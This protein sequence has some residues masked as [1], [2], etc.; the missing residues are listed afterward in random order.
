VR[1]LRNK[2]SEKIGD[3]KI[4]KIIRHAL[5]RTEL[6]R[7]PDVLPSGYRDK[8]I[9]ETRNFSSHGSRRSFCGVFC[10]R[11]LCDDHGHVE[12][13]AMVMLRMLQ[14]RD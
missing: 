9:R 10:L 14:V 1:E 5:A 6:I 2:I 12:D 13:V 3:E 4:L 11:D 8:F 7:G